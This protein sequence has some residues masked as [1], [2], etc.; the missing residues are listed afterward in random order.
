M[1]SRRYLFRLL[2]CLIGEKLTLGP[3]SKLASAGG[4]CQ[5]VFI[6][7]RSWYAL[8]RLCGLVEITRALILGKGA[9][10]HTIGKSF[11]YDVVAFDAPSRRALR[12]RV[13]TLTTIGLK[14]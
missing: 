8:R 9:M 3:S 6:T 7:A 5:G 1:R 2:G 13:S 10:Y 11:L 12:R 4:P 14:N